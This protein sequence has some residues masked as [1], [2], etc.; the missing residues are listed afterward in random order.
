LPLLL[1]DTNGD[2]RGPVS[3]FVRE[4]PEEP[5]GQVTFE[6]ANLRP[7]TTNLPF[8]VWVSQRSGAKHDVRVKVA[9]SAKV[10]PSQMGVYSVRPFAH[11]EGP[12]LS[13]SEEKLLANW[14]E[15]NKAVLVD[16]WNADIEYTEDLI[17]KIQAV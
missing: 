16:F 15:K 17:D 4:M 2:K 3:H 7:K 5:E 9:H 10:I 12:G 1:S 6:M 13:P 14:V 8:V 11:L